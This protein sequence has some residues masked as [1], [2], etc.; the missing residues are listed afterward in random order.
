MKKL[1]FSLLMLCVITGMVAGCGKESD[2]DTDTIAGKENTDTI[3]NTMTQ[4]VL[5]GVFSIGEGKQIHFSQG[6]LQ[7]QASTNTWRFATEQYDYSGADNENISATY[8]GWIDNFAWGTSGW[9]ESGATAYMPYSILAEADLYLIGGTHTVDLIGDYANADWGVFNAISNGGNKAGLWRT[10]TA[11]EWK[12]LLD[13]RPNAHKLRSIAHVCGH[14]GI[15]LLPDNWNRKDI[16]F[17]PEATY[18]VNNYDAETWPAL[19]K[20]GAVFLPATGYRTVKAIGVQ[21]RIGMYWSVNANKAST[22]YI[23]AVVFHTGIDDK[24]GAWSIFPNGECQRFLGIPTRLVRDI[25]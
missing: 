18:N 19:Q 9:A 2:N 20:A 3:D 16:P 11:Q 4:G 8:D 23:Y 13:E 12:Y 22:E 24:N 10:M 15:L 17:T 1:T 6:V 25:E 5:Q 14:Y 21:E 7:Y